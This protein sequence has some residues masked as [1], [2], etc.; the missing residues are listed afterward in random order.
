VYAAADFYPVTARTFEAT[1][2]RLAHGAYLVESV[3]GFL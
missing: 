2:T 3:I 1:P